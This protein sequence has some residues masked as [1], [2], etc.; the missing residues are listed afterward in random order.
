MKSRKFTLIELLVVIAIIA[1][2][3][4][5]LL[6]A[7]NSA[8]EKAKSISCVNNLKGLG[9]AYGMYAGE[10]E[11]YV[12]PA[13][14][15]MG[16]AQIWWYGLL[17][18]QVNRETKLFICPSLSNKEGLYCYLRND[19]YGTANERLIERLSYVQNSELG[20]Q[21]DDG[22]VAAYTKLG[23]WRK[24]TLS[25]TLIDGRLYRN[26]AGNGSLSRHV[27]PWFT[28]WNIGLLSVSYR[29]ARIANIAFLDGHVQSVQHSQFSSTNGSGDFV[30]Y[31]Y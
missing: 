22:S 28:Y 10:N 21:N 2:L 13:Q 14:L 17:A 29:H 8:R 31:N 4:A 1:I 18:P 6:P 25:V 20:G 26:A 27:E 15:V 30:W 23:Q 7:L 12:V 5:M 16:G 24:P 19:E 11:D 9:L 3:A